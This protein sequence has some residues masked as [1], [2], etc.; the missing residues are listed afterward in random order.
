MPVRRVVT[1]HD[2]DGRSIVT[3][4]EPAFEIPFGSNGGAAHIVWGRDDVA[5]FPDDGSP[6]ATVGAFP[7]PGGCRVS[8]SVLPPGESTDFD[9]LVSTAL[10][11]YAEPGRPGM[12]R[13]ASLDFDVVLQGTIGLELDDG[14]VVL[15]AGDI[16]V[17]NGTRHRWHNRGEGPA[18]FAAIVLGAHHELVPPR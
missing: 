8:V 14:E 1:G 16:V 12:H 7:P 9:E 4:D 18:S 2:E 17:Q 6:P 13:T 5:R 3:S 11:E 10:A 15:H